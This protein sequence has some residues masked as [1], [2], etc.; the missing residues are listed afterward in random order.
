MR[1][2]APA[3]EN[4]PIVADTS[5]ACLR[6]T[7]D[8]EARALIDTAIGH[9]QLAIGKGDGTISRRH[10]LDFLGRDAAP[11]PRTGIALRYLREARPNRGALRLTLRKGLSVR[12]APGVFV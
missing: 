1:R 3:D 5:R 6:Q 9:H 7:G 10:G 4:Q 8:D 11:Q 2:R 12:G